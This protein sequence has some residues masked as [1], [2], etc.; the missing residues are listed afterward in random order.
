MAARPELEVSPTSVDFGSLQPGARSTRT[1]TITGRGVSA[2]L[3]SSVTVQGDDAFFA[4]P[5]V[6]REL[7]GGES[8]QVEVVFAPRARGPHAARLVITS[9]AVNAPELLV[10][11]VG[12][13]SG[14]APTTCAAQQKNCGTL[15]DGCSGQ[16]D[17]GV[18]AGV[19]T[20]GGRGVPNVC[21]CSETDAALC[22]RLTKN[23]GTL[24]TVDRCGSRRSVDCGSC[25]APAVCSGGG[26]TNVCACTAETDMAFCTRVGRQCGPVTATDA[27]G[28]A[29]TVDCGSCAAPNSCGGGGTA[30]MCGCTMES[31][32]AICTRLNATCGT[33]TAMSCGVQRT[34]SC[35]TCTMPSTCGGG[36]TVNVCA[37]AAETDTAFC[38]RLGKTCGSVTA[39]DSCG[40]MRTASCGTCAMPAT[41]GGG[42]TVNVC[43][44]AGETDV[45]FCMRV[46]AQCGPVTA[47]DTCGLMRTTTWRLHAPGDVWRCGHG[48]PL[49]LC[50]DGLGVLHAAPEELRA[51]ERDRCV[52]RGENGR[53]RS[54]R[55]HVDV[56]RD[57][58]LLL[59]ARDESG[60]LHSDQHGVWKPH[61]CRQLRHAAHRRLRAVRNVR[62]AGND[63]SARP[64]RQRHHLGHLD[65]ERHVWRWLGA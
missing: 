37:C 26:T 48:E 19:E 36:G 2:V 63:S 42:G 8:L 1:V 38:T 61:R 28:M 53:V 7:A 23:C 25:T 34:V 31:D 20:C 27:C 11:I 4:T 3:L 43:G 10:P 30:N 16:L 46:G 49:R 24:T 15:S 32:T 29:R 41:C 45:A 54:V 47:A 13:A 22:T 60:L 50:R 57:E 55:R 33:V 65:D 35:G 58:R 6:S 39:A 14:C 62:R 9:N 17:C 64:R 18:C 52:W 51:G 5:V 59:Y 21:G 40:Q 44:C 56:W 12:D